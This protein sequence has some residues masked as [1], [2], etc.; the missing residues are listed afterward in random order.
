MVSKEAMANVKNDV[1]KVTVMSVV[2]GY[3]SGKNL[4]DQ[5]WQLNLAYTLLGFALY[6]V[7][8]AKHVTPQLFKEYTAMVQDLTKVSTMLVTVKLLSARDVAS[9]MNPQWLM[10]SALTLAGFATYHLVTKKLLD[11]SD[12]N[13]DWKQISDDLLKVGTMLVVSH[14]LGGGDVTDRNFV[15]NSANTIL[16]FNLGSIFDF[17]G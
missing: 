16:G 13:G 6:E 3:L 9:L 14:Y 1:V 11:T 2:S 12:R 7:V 10:T 5:E 8:L 17:A 4:M 15:Q